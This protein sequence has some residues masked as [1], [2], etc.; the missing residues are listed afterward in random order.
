MLNQKNLYHMKSIKVFLSLLTASLLVFSCSLGIEDIAG[1]YRLNFDVSFSGPG[2]TGSSK[3]YINSVTVTQD[4]DI[5]QV[6]GNP[7][8]I[9]KKEQVTFSGDIIMDGSQ[10]LD[11]ELDASS[12]EINGTLTGTME[13]EVFNGYSYQTYTVTITSGS[14][15]LIPL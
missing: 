13:L 9:D 2:I 8:T 6:S 1:D 12:G 7:G 15:T 5:I 14:C 11:G 10:H 4:E 3:G